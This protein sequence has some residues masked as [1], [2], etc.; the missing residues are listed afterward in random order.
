M[1]GNRKMLFDGIIPTLC[2]VLFAAIGK[3][4]NV[5]GR[6]FG[7]EGLIVGLLFCIAVSAVLILNPVAEAKIGSWKAWL[8][9]SGLIAMCSWGM[10]VLRNRVS[11]DTALK[12]TE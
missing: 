8:R 11:S 3:C 12:N 9:M 10:L 1:I 4:I 2:I 6:H 7:H 5:K